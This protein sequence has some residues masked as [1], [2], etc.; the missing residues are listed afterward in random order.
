MTANRTLNLISHAMNPLTIILAIIFLIL[1]LSVV[2]ISFSK[3][4]ERSFHSE[5][6]Y[7]E[8]SIYL[9]ISEIITIVLAILLFLCCTWRI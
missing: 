8:V 4:R 3:R 7:K 5:R 9:L 6:A 1:A 2:I